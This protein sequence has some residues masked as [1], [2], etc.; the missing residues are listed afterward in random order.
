MKN[1][2]RCLILSSVTLLFFLSCKKDKKIDTS[3]EKYKNEKIKFSY[4]ITRTNGIKDTTV[5]F[6][7]SGLNTSE[8]DNYGYFQPSLGFSILTRLNPDNFQNNILIFF[9]GTD[10]NTLSLPYTFSGKDVYKDAQINYKVGYCIIKDGSGQD[11]R[12][13]N[14]YAASTNSDGFVV[15]ILSKVDNRL[16]GTFR[17]KIQNQDGDVINVRKGIFDI[18]IVEK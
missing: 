9:T 7:S 10:L 14:T 1:N 11:I 12:V 8:L 16:K 3:V 18:Q 15:T 6:T 13:F 17:G 2:F 4:S 5:V